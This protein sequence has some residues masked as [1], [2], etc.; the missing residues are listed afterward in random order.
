MKRWLAPLFG[1]FLALSSAWSAG[2]IVVDEAHWHPPGPRP[3]IHPPPWPPPPRPVP[4][5]PRAPVYRFAPLEVARLQA[6]VRILDQVAT[7]TIDQEF[8]N[9]ND[10]R[11]EG[12]FY[13]PVPKGA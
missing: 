8:H 1:M 11:M 2:F 5:R 3:P 4:P 6:D 7:T 10:R 12:T 13:F 9:P